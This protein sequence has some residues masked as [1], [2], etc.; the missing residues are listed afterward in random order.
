MIE[1]LEGQLS[2]FDQDSWFGKTS[3]EHSVPTKEKTSNRSSRKSS[4][5]SA[6]M[7]PMFLYLRRDGAS[8]D[9]SWVTEK[10]DALFP[11]LGDYT[12]PSTGVQPSMLMAECS[13]PELPS[14][15]SVS[16][17]SQILEE[18]ALPK[19]YLSERACTGILRR[20]E[21]RKKEL[22]PIL[23]M[24]LENQIDRARDDSES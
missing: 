6:P 2:F 19:Y 18:D 1:Q 15:V 22:P 16:H 17:L 20:A 13:Q 23:K 24:A 3:P 21:R 12:M 5:S 14:G 11:S 7:L 4:K 10:T 8:Q 9:A